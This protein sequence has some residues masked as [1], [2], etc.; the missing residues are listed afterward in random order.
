MRKFNFL[1]ISL[2]VLLISAL[3]YTVVISSLILF[4]AF[5]LVLIFLLVYFLNPIK[6]SFDYYKLDG[7]FFLSPLSGYVSN[8]ETIVIS[9]FET[10]KKVT[11][12]QKLL[13]PKGLFSPFNG[14]LFHMKHKQTTM[15]SFKS[16]ND[17]VVKVE[18]S[19]I[20]KS[21]KTLLWVRMGDRFKTNACIGFSFLPMK[22]DVL[23]PNEWEILVYS[24]ELLTPGKSVIGVINNPQLRMI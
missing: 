2:Y 7:E 12:T 5:F 22:V 6:K 17:H 4:I 1:P 9:D 11:I 13:S 19:S 24:G 10:V 20:Y 15:I 21:L 23:L 3:I 18:I 16:K 8:I 14:E